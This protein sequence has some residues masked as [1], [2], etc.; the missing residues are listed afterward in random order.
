[1]AS[2][3][4]LAYNLPLKPRITFK[5]IDG[6]DTYFTF[7]GHGSPKEINLVYADMDNAMGETGTFNIIV[8]DSNNVIN[9]DHLHNAKVY[10]ELGK[11]QASLEHFLIGYADI[12]DIE[13]PRTNYMDYR[14]S[15]FGSQI[16]ADELLLLIRKQQKDKNDADFTVKSLFKQSLTENNF[17]PMNRASEDVET[18]TN[19]ESDIS[20]S[21]K[22]RYP[23]V[24]EVFTTLHD[25]YDRL[26]ALDGCVWYIDFTGGVETLTARN[27]LLLHSHK[28]IKSGDLRSANDD[29][30]KVSYIKDVFSI[31]D[32]SS[33]N[34]GI[35]TRLYTTTTLEGELIKENM[36][37][38]G[39]TLLNQR[40]LA[41]QVDVLNDQRRMTEVT[42]IMERIGEP[43]SPKNRVNGFIIL[44]EADKPRG[45]I[46][47]TFNIDLG[48]LERD[49]DPIV[50]TVDPKTRF[51]EGGGKFWFVFTDRSGIKGNIEN[52]PDNT[53]AWHHDNTVNT[54]HTSGNY[55][56]TA[57]A[58][59]NF[60]DDPT[61]ADWQVSTNGP[62]Y[63]YSIKST[64][65]RLLARSNQSAI[66]K[67][68]TKEAFIDSSFLKTPESV[69]K[70]LAL[71]LNP[72][73]KTRRTI[74]NI[75]VTVPNNFIYRPYEYVTFGDGLSAVSQ[76]LQI[77][78]A[79]YIISALPG[80][81][82]YG[83]YSAEL[84]LNGSFNSLVGSCTCE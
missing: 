43:A 27:P 61:K 51:L 20:D 67:L 23:V 75:R 35:K 60:R 50:V 53:V 1:M 33:S 82:Q 62:V 7:N 76:D 42:F 44:D 36:S 79:A 14:I 58:D 12:M 26:S 59:E 9:K 72:I 57:I 77:V 69:N 68:R 41:Q 81:P 6:E 66:K 74:N 64:I 21:L 70:F 4:D 15:G 45:T 73:S 32:D 65:K 84:T 56:A 22:S 80:D 49:P 63:N 54:A 13:R 71:N 40:F 25:F 10:L 3:W 19:W 17:R 39:R 48:Q 18:L 28:V 47:S 16:Q 24:S 29:P 37:D 8:E 11:T 31:T 83:T 30:N 46:L 2:T 5:S 55:S 78:R 38:K 52:D 34:A